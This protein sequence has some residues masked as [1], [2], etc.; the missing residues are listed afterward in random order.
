MCA[1]N[2]M[3][4]IFLPPYFLVLSP[5]TLPLQTLAWQTNNL[6]LLAI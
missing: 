4:M 3:Y 6:D 2:F 1:M 5:N